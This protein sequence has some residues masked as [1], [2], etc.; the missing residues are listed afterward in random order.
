M[1]DEPSTTKFEPMTPAELA[2]ALGVP[3]SQRR[4]PDLSAAVPNRFITLTESQARGMSWCYDPS[5]GE[6]RYHHLAARRSSNTEICADCERTKKGLA[7]IY[8]KSVVNKHYDAPR[9]A[10]K[11]HPSTA[12]APSPAKPEL[13]KKDRDIVTALAETRDFDKA[14]EQVGCT[15]GQ[16]DAQLAVSEPLRKAVD[17]LG[18]PRT[19]APDSTRDWTDELMRNIVRRFVDTGM[20]ET[21]RTDCGVSASEFY[22]QIERS[23]DFAAAIEAARPKARDVLR[24]KATQAASVGRV[25]LLK[26]LEAQVAEDSIGDMS[27]EQQ[28][29]ELLKLIEQLDKTGVIPHTL[30]YKRISTGEILRADDLQ[31]HETTHSR[32]VPATDANLDLVST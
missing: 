20:L 12:A 14:A 13:A 25:D 16:L 31:A 3:L 28:S 30:S 15:R 21:A 2:A 10:A 18:I 22:E 19:R 32:S 6:C 24:D 26:Y 9:R 7:P 23:P 5:L 29:A 27:P 8:G 1:S 11:D 17:E 4:Q